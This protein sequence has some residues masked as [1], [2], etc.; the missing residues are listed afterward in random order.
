M[1]TG[2]Y[3]DHTAQAAAEL[4]L[5]DAFGDI[6]E[7]VTFCGGRA[8]DESNLGTWTVEAQG[9]RDRDRPQRP[10]RRPDAVRTRTRVRV[11]DLH[12]P[13]QT[14]EPFARPA[15][16]IRAVQTQVRRNRAGTLR[17]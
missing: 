4:M 9:Q 12:R 15:R 14:S 13:P 1:S 6:G 2:R 16:S 3:D 5:R 10:Y 11:M 7:R 8:A 17:P